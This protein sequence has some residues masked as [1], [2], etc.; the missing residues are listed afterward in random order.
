MLENSESSLI[1]AARSGD[2]ASLS[3]LFQPLSRELQAYAY[4][5]LGGFQDAE[6]AVQEARLKAWRSLDSYEPHASFRAW[7]YRIVTNTCLDVLRTRKRRVL[8][9][10]DSGPIEAG[11]PPSEMRRDIPWL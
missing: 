6:D 1:E 5:M 7:M 4:R 3:L 8:P 11:P 9:R 10:D 2:Q